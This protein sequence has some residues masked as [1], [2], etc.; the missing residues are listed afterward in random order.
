M[1]AA[2]G[3]RVDAIMSPK[4]TFGGNASAMGDFVRTAFGVATTPPRP[5]IVVR[6]QGAHLFITL[7]GRDSILFPYGHPLE[8]QPRYQWAEGERGILYGYLKPEPD[9]DAADQDPTPRP[10]FA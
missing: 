3:R 6:D 4:G 2:D 9:S 5:P 7:D 1:A 8:T 10:R